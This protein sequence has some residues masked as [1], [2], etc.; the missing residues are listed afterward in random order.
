[1]V[2]TFISFSFLQVL[3][4]KLMPTIRD[5]VSLSSAKSF[6]EQ[7]LNAGGLSLIIKVL[8]KDSIPHDVDY[9][10]RQGI[11]TIALQILRSADTHTHAHIY[12]PQHRDIEFINRIIFCAIRHLIYDLPIVEQYS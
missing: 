2:L 10:T 9:L 6:C 1:M 12:F 3:S 8:Q 5:S 7:F 4:S 11:Y